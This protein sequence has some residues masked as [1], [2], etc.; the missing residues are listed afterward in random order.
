MTGRV[1]G[2]GAK[3]AL[4][5]PQKLALFEV[6]EVPYAVAHRVVSP[7]G[8][9]QT[10]RTANNEWSAKVAIETHISDVIEVDAALETALKVYLD[11][12]IALGTKVLRIE[13]GGAGNVSGMVL[14]PREERD[15]LKTR[16]V[17]LVPFYRHHL[18]IQDPGSQAI[19]VEVLR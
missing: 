5:G 19:N 18:Q 1:F 6:L 3:M 7:D 15:F 8:L 9:L 12:W 17:I 2:M 13:G 14:D 10:E 16:V 11:R 4:S